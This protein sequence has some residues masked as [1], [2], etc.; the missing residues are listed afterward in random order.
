MNT[1]TTTH[2]NTDIAKR[3]GQTV[4]ISHLSARCTSLTTTS[5]IVLYKKQAPNTLIS[6]QTIQPIDTTVAN[7]QHIPTAPET[8]ISTSTKGILN[9]VNTTDNKPNSDNVEHY[10]VN[11]IKLEPNDNTMQASIPIQVVLMI[12]NTLPIIEHTKDHIPNDNI[13]MEQV[14][15]NYIKSDSIEAAKQGFIAPQVALIKEN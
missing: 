2:T 9:N 1:Q 8:H 11:I 12:A 15:A 13:D 4:P 10:V 6:T 14:I 7:E 5:I 3:S